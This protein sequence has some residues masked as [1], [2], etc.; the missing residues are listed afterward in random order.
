[1]AFSFTSGTR[2]VSIR[3]PRAQLALVRDVLLTAAMRATLFPQGRTA[4]GRTFRE[5]LPVASSNFP[6]YHITF[7]WPMWSHCL[8]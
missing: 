1:M 6:T 3:Y 2:T 5:E 4:S 8:G 7:I